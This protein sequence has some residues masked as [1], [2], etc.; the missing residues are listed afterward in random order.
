MAGWSA[1]DVPDQSGRTAVVTGGNTGLGLETAKVLAARGATVVIAARDRAKAERAISA[2]GGDTSYLPLDLASLASVREAAA[3]LRSAHDRIDLLIN[4]AGV[5]MTPQGTTEDG[6]ELQYGTNHL[7]HFALTGLLLD[8]MTA[9]PGSRVVIVSSF[10][11][12]QGSYPPRERYNPSRA[13]G[14]S[15]LANLLFMFELQRRLA[16]A[17]AETIS[18]AAH[19]G[20]ANTGLN[21]YLPAPTRIATQIAGPVVAQSAASGALPILRAA[22]DPSARG[23]QFYGPRWLMWGPPVVSSPRSTALDREAAAQLWAESEKATGVT[24]AL[25]SKRP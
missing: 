5:M 16:A 4:N 21:R 23:G 20:Y 8:R 15:K 18:L 9:V 2:I 11:H 25:A 7:G 3:E 24:Y 22:T 17:G 10:V 12:R 14:D 13:Y 19:P 6:F 1:A